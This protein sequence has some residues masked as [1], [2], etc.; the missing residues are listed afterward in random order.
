MRYLLCYHTRTRKHNRSEILQSFKCF[1]KN[2]KVQSQDER[3]RL[4]GYN[5]E[6]EKYYSDKN[7]Y[8]HL[9]FSMAYS[10]TSQD[11]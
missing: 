10:T 3:M 8:I 2:D 1:I 7:T 11:K 4:K 5:L 6:D 9:Q